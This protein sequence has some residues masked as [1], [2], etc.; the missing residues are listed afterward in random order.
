VAYPCAPCGGRRCNR[1]GFRG[2]PRYIPFQG[3]LSGSQ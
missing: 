1:A 3:S 2:V